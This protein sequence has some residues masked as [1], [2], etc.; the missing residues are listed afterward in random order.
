MQYKEFKYTKQWNPNAVPE[1][2]EVQRKSRS[3]YHSNIYTAYQTGAVTY[4]TLIPKHINQNADLDLIV[5]KYI[6]GN[7]YSVKDLKESIDN[8]YLEK[9]A[10][11][12]G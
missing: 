10:I 9:G 1:G 4:T 11:H 6:L 12:N 7:F 3:F 8:F 5:I 2:Y